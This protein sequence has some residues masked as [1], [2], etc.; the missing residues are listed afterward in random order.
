MKTKS[1]RNLFAF[2]GRTCSSCAMK[3]C[4]KFAALLAILFTFVTIPARQARAE[5]EEPGYHF[6]VYNKT[7]DTIVKLL[8]F[9]DG[10]KKHP[11]DNGRRG[12]PPGKNITPP[13]EEKNQKN[14]FEWFIKT[15]FDDDSETP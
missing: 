14:G 9:E 11:F 4:L 2:P 10:K 3:P 8:A 5:D 13:W 7:K 12:L 15:I 6:K 1:A